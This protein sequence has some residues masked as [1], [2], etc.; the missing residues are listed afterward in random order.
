MKKT[1]FSAGTVASAQAES[2]SMNIST[3][4]YL[5]PSGGPLLAPGPGAIGLNGPFLKML[6]SQSIVSE[7][8]HV[9][10]HSDQMTTRSERELAL[11]G[12]SRRNTQFPDVF[13]R[14]KL[15]YLYEFKF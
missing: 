9:S 5:M 12:W 10:L 7:K 6:M 4:W 1:T 3:V 13:E 14:L 15:L 8:Y 11:F 2:S